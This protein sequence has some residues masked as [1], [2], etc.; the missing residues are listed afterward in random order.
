MLA[1]VNAWLDHLLTDDESAAFA[2]AGYFLVSEAIDPDLL[3]RLTAVVDDHD[4][5]FRSQPE[6]GPMHVL[7]EHDLIGKDDVWLELLDLSTTFPKVFGIMGWHIRLFHTQLLVTPPV[8]PHA[9]SGAYAWHQDN[10]RMNRDLETEFHPMISLKVAYFLTDLPAPGMGNLCVAPGSHRLAAGAF[11]A[12]DDALEVTAN[13]G[14]AIVFDRRL[15][16]SASSNRSEV[17]RQFV[18]FGYAYRW[19]QPKSAMQ[20][21]SLYDTVDPIRRQL[22]GFATTANGYYDPQP[23]DVPLRAW[24]RA[25][26]IDPEA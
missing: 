18:T 1:V 4:R 6:V 8:G 20:H 14:D 5:R 9:Q 13:A 26:S 17:T 10:N 25:A 12:P 23:D 21:E 3:A 16:H 11:R 19:L 7:N 24:M 22:L 2:H 15:W